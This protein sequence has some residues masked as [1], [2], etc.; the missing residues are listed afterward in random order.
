MTAPTVVQ[1][2]APGQPTAADPRF[3]DPAWD[4]NALFRGILAAYRRFESAIRARV[5]AV[6]G[7]WQRRARARLLGE[8]A[9]GLAAPTNWVLG[10]PAALRRAFATRGASLRRGAANMARDVVVNRGIPST[11]DRTPYKVGR[12]LACTPGAVVHREDMFELIQYAPTS[13][14]VAG[15]PLV[16]V[17]PPAN[18]HYVLDLAP[19]RS[20][21]EASVAAGVQT[22]MVV[23]RNPFLPVHGRWGLEDHVGAVLRA[24]AV[25]REI[26]RTEEAN[27]LGL[28]GGGIVAALA[29]ANLAAADDASVRSAT[30]LATMLTN[31]TG[32]VI[33][34]LTPPLARRYL[35]RAA[36]RGKVFGGRALLRTFAWLRPSD[37][38]F[39]YV[40]DGWLLGNKPPAHDVLAWNADATGASA[41]MVRD[42]AEFIVGDWARVPGG[43]TILGLPVDFR[44]VSVDTFHVL[45]RTD[46]LVPWR[47]AHEAA[48]LIGGAS[49]VVLGDAG[50]ILSFVA[51]PGDRKAAYW[52]DGPAT[53]DP[54]EWLAGAT[55][56]LES[57]WPRWTEWLVSRSGP[58]R[59]AP[60]SLG[61]AVHPP[62]YAA[63]GR[64]VHE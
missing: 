60:G 36:D 42:V 22:F 26:C 61:T 53:A 57:W 13:A 38:V 52:A 7:P 15:I 34:T 54:D 28:C 45:G 8:I 17:P 32:N 21:A 35:S 3:A 39:R 48:C 14:F 40:V 11:V 56:L 37:F 30:F 46:H 33:G 5:D 44:R 10:N 51:P 1:D 50:H 24:I 49:E 62:L 47:G 18:R 27:L 59:P 63:P 9:V 2:E 16:M 29:L 41:A 58:S 6:E 23:W 55:H 31:A 19:G 43:A 25:A 4:R 20:L 12:D 64:Y